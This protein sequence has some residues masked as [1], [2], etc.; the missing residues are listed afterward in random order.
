MKH[1][2]VADVMT[3][4]VFSVGVR[5]PFKYLAELFVSRRISA[6]P[7]LG[8]DGTV[9]GIVGETDLLKKE[10]AQQEP[11]AGRLQWHRRAFRR[12]VAADTAGELMTTD[13]LTIRPEAT[14]AEAAQL[15]DRH[16]VTCLPVVDATG[17]L[18]G[19]VSPRDLLRV[20]VRPDQEIRDQIFDEVL[21]GY[22]GT[23]PVLVTVNVRNGLVSL[24]GEVG[25]MSMIPLVLPL[26]RAVD[27]VVDAEAELTYA[28]DDTHRPAA[29]SET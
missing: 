18:Q 29:I 14:V 1:R 27:G 17:R 24:S 2:T 3:T 9:A 19:I 15:M 21:T 8:D 16:N 4:E 7:V 20:F 10:E 5:A 28:L 25:R 11:A 13:V 26:V 12:R 22:L 6:L 23:N